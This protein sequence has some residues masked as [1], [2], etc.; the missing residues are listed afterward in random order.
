[1]AL[2]GTNLIKDHVL[3][4]RP[5]ARIVLSSEALTQTPSCAL[6]F[7]PDDWKQR[8]RMLASII[9]DQKPGVRALWRNLACGLH[10]VS[11]G[12][13]RFLRLATLLHSREQIVVLLCGELSQ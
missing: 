7:R 2:I 4:T 5:N 6:L 13:R 10:S 9:C 8:R 1:M 11:D 3:R 12:S